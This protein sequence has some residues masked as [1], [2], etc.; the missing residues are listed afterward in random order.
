LT[1]YDN[2][3]KENIAMGL[4]PSQRSLSL[5]VILPCWSGS[6]C[7]LSCLFDISDALCF[8]V[9]DYRIGFSNGDR[10]KLVILLFLLCVPSVSAS[11]IV[12]PA[13]G[14]LQAALNTAVCGDEIVVAAGA[15]F[16]TSQPFMVKAKACAANPIT[17]RTSAITSLPAVGLRISQAD[18]PNM[19]K[20][21]TT[22]SLNVL[23][24]EANASG[25]KFIGIEFTN[26]GGDILTN[27]LIK[28]GS[29]SSGQTIIPYAQKPNNIWFDRCWIHEATNDT[30][31]P[32]SAETTA[33]RGFNI[34]G[35]H[36]KITDSR[37][38]GFRG[39]YKGTTNIVASNAILFPQSPYDVLVDNSYLE[40]WFV[41][42][43]FGGSGGE[44]DNIATVSNPTFNATTKTGTATLSTVQNLAVGDLI[45]FKVTGGMNGNGPISHQVARIT[46]ISGN[47]VNFVSQPSSVAGSLNGGNPLTVVPDSPG[48]ALWNGY[49]PE[50][51]TIRHSRIELKFEPT[52]YVWTHIK[53]DPG[54]PEFGSSTT[55]PTKQQKYYGAAPKGSVEIKIGKRITFDGNTFGGW[56][57]G[58]TITTR[59]QG[60][61]NVSGAYP[62]STIDDFVFTNNYIMKGVNWMRIFAGGMGLQGEDNECTSM[63][64]KNWLI[65]NNL[66]ADGTFNF[67][68]MG[69]ITNLTVRHNTYPTTQ[70]LGGSEFIFIYGGPITNLIFEDNISKNNEYG[71]NCQV[72]GGGCYPGLVQSKNVIIDNRSADA[73]NAEQLQPKY[74]NDFIAASESA[75]GFADRANG[76]YGLSSTSPFKGLGHNGTDPGVDMARLQAALGGLTPPPTPTPTPSP[77]PAP[78]PTPTPTPGPVVG[79]PSGS[80]VEIISPANIRNVP[81]ISRTVTFIAATGVRGVTAGNCQRDTASVNIYCFVNFSDGTNGWAANQFL[82][83]VVTPTPTP[84]PTPSP[85]ASPS[86]PQQERLRGRQRRVLRMP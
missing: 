29:R 37:I 11:T 55:L 63:Q 86:P 79:P 34:N 5:G 14:D 26:I 61:I 6:G 81:S 65:E 2:S 57:G 60:D 76:N 70:V 17:I 49:L 44:T 68:K 59:N 67:L 74:P 56:G 40:A 62:W 69:G 18:G 46:S 1:K 82:R 10:M 77:A 7:L 19:A 73:K 28:L 33:E 66:F 24:F 54:Q 31:T 42:I 78:S 27:E 25:Y 13:G 15:T 48:Q 84:S 9:D 64:G 72:T 32:L 50:N 71:M 75:V 43:F 52:E 16:A 4:F 80:T 30:T 36:I 83:L 58:F 41:V 8:V 45:A 3:E 12:V 35:A 51:I 85:R 38:A 20:L 23:E 22:S 53:N 39:F 47:S 21:V